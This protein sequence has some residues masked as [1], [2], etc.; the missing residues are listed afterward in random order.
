MT[1]RLTNK[2]KKT[3]LIPFS[4]LLFILVFT[5]LGFLSFIIKKFKKTSTKRT[6][7]I[8]RT[9]KINSMEKQF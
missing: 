8:K 2:F 6:F 4:F 5:P 3:I 7:W 1:S 9:K